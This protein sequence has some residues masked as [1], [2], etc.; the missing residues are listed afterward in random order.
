[1]KKTIKG[2]LTLNTAIFIVA[3]IIVCEIVSVNALKTNM[4][5][6]TR[7][8]VSR[9]AQTNARV[10]NEWLQGQANTVH[11][12][13]NTIAFMNTKDTDHV[14]D[15]L[16]KALSENKEAL[17]YY[18]CF[19]YDGGVF[20]AN[21][22]KIDL[23]PTTRDWWKQAIKKNSLI[24]TAPYKDFASGKMIVTIAEPLEIKGEQ[25]VVLADITIDTLT[26][27][28]SNV[29][30]DENI[31]GFLLDADGMVVSHQNKDY[32]PKEEG[33]TSL[34][35][36]LSVN[37]K[38]VSEITDYDGYSKFIHTAQITATG[39]TFGVTE[40]ESVV[41]TQVVKSV[42]LVVGIGVVILILVVLLTI[43]SVKKNLRPLENMKTFIREKVIGD[44]QKNV[45]KNEVEE[46]SY[47]L[48]ELEQRFIGVIR[49]TKDESDVIHTRVENTND[50]VSLINQNIMEIS[51]AMEE[52]GANIDSQTTSIQNIDKT[53]KDTTHAVDVLVSHAEEMSDKAKEIGERVNEAVQKLMT[54]KDSAVV[55]AD[56]SRNRMQMAIQQTKII[57]EITTVSA[58]IEEI[59]SQTNL[60]AL[61]ASIEAARAGEAGKGF[62]VVATEIGALATQ[63]QN[64]V[65]DID[66][67]IGEVHNAVSGMVDCLQNAMDFLENTVLG[68]YKG[69]ME[70]GEKYSEDAAAFEDGMTKINHSIVT[71][72][73]AITDI[74]HSI[75]EINLTVNESATGVSDIAEKTSEM[76]RK[77][78]ATGTFMQDSEESANNLN[79]IVSEFDL[80]G[81]K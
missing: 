12:I 58:S 72:V 67:I 24:Y 23:D 29:S 19:G 66:S 46:I 21:H 50:K 42:I 80:D 61:N 68:D 1:M 2:K 79:Q 5:N 33:N 59:A 49:K 40:R 30:T 8:Y 16:E 10:V 64:A 22:S 71:L 60:L 45:H 4:T 43:A 9:E 74:S 20:P 48:Q 26:K 15:Y 56:E 13:T 28:V 31:Q 55:K 14:M 34:A 78:E 81:K 69:F 39:W 65:G 38:E 7:Q 35:K 62:A 36:A 73:D 44:S 76:V 75:E 54:D 47:L 27:L 53:C 37:V 41:T 51:A 18:L 17:M 11:T 52:T 70:V 25:A 63:T 3:A 77:I 6:Q 32:L 57:G